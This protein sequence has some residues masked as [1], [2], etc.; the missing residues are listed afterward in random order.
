MVSGVMK[1][2]GASIQVDNNEF[3]IC[4][5]RILPA[6]GS[7]ELRL[8]SNAFVLMLCRPPTNYLG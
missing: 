8:L 3:L 7:K 5:A 4:L 1:W 2:G 6:R